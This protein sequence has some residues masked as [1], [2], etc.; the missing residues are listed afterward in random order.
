[1]EIHQETAKFAE[2][3]SGSLSC[4]EN[5]LLQESLDAK[6][7][8]HPQLFVRDNKDKDERGNFPTRLVIPAANFTA[9]FSKIGYMGTKRVLGEHRVDYPKHTTIQSLDLKT[10]L[11]GLGLRRDE[12]TMMSLDIVNMYPSIRVKLIK[13]ALQHYSRSLPAEA[14]Q[15]I[16]FGMMM[17]QFEMKN[18]LVN[19]HDK[20]YIYQGAAKGHDILEEDVAQTIGGFESVFLADLVASFVFEKMAVCFKSALF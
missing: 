6:A 5:G 12:V 18:T 4:G 3:L 9:T 17:V 2:K 11:E 16:K 14:K 19:F 13:K 10:K 15:R 1:M 7:I 8:P 20:F